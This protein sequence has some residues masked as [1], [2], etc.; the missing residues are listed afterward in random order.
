MIRFGAESIAAFLCPKSIID[1]EESDICVYGLE[2]LLTGFVNVASIIL[3]GILFNKIG[4]AFIYLF[5]MMVIRTYSGGY[6]AST[7]LRCILL[8][9]ITFGIT[10]G[11]YEC[12]KEWNL[13]LF[14]FYLVEVGLGVVGYCSPIE[15]A[16]KELS[17]VQC[18]KYKFISVLLYALV[19]SISILLFIIG[20]N[21]YV[22]RYGS[23]GAIC[24]EISIY[25]NIVLITI[26]VMIIICKW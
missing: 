22:C 15:N 11:I 12:V 2:L 1:E 3:L 6:H 4:L 14:L 16:N 18:K 8:F 13:N 17:V 9:M 25:I 20:N 10:L 5:L 23:M 21:R 19:N 26:F 24:C 7:H